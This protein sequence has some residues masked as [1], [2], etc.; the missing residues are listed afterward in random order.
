M[1]YNLSEITEVIK[2]RRTIKPEDFSERK[3]QQDIIENI[4]E[5]AKWAPTHGLTQPWFFKV[6]TDNGI[7]KLAEFQSEKYRE[8]TPCAQFNLKKY[9]QL[10][11]RPKLASVIIAICMKRKEGTNIPEIEDIEAVACAVQ[12]MHLVA[13]AYGLGAYWGSGGLTYHEEMKQFLNLGKEDKCLG[14]FYLGYP[15]IE[16]PKGQRRPIEYYTEWVD[17]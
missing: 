16:W 12:N 10:K 15:K 14:F 6:F 13:T 3:V 4:L 7:D 11:N 8:I 9:N 2:N 17:S 1:K 5:N